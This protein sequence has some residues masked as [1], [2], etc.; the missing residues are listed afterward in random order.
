VFLDDEVG[1]MLKIEKIG[2]AYPETKANE[3]FGEWAYFDN[4]EFVS[5]LRYVAE[6]PDE[7]RKKGAAGANRMR[8]KFTPEKAALQLDEIFMDYYTPLS[9]IAQDVGEKEESCSGQIIDL[10]T[11]KVIET[12]FDEHYFTQQHKYT[13]EFHINVAKNI[14]NVTYGLKEKAIDVGCGNGFL[15]KHLLEEGADVVGIDISKWAVEHPI[16]G[17]EGRIFWGDALDIPYDDKTFDWAVSFSVLEHLP[18]SYTEQALSEIRRVAKKAFVE[19]AMIVP[20]WTEER[21]KTEDPTHINVKPF[22]WWKEKIENAGFKILWYD[23]CMSMILEAV[24]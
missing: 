5:L 11:G 21:L 20:G 7:C 1:W 14:M 10:S 6:H 23:N 19:I 4:M 8:E 2:K 24:E 18:E 12:F 9:E 16:E 15:M 22:S 3:D 17:C 13:P